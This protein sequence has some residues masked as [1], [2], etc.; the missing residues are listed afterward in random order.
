MISYVESRPMLQTYG[1]TPRRTNLESLDN[2]CRCPAE[3]VNEDQLSVMLSI[4]L[5]QPTFRTIPVRSL[6]MLVGGGSDET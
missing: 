5:Y 1:E 6:A 3:D 4:G 2:R